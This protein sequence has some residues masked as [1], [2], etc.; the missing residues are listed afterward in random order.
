MCMFRKKTLVRAISSVPDLPVFSKTRI[1]LKDR[2]VSSV[3]INGPDH[4][5][6]SSSMFISGN[7]LRTESLSVTSIAS[8]D[9]VGYRHYKNSIVA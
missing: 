7:H 8:H 4:R 5:R 3:I 9:E 2:I 1:P 6:K